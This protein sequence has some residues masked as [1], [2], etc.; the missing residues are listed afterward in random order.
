VQFEWVPGHSGIRGNEI[1]D[2]LAKE[3]AINEDDRLSNNGYILL[4]HVKV[5]VRRSCLKD[6]TKYIMKMHRKKRMGRFYMQYF[7]I[8]STYWK[9]CKIITAKRTYAVLN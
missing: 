5:S 6:W 2:Q 3:A 8:K 7:G 9:A 1:V 4:T